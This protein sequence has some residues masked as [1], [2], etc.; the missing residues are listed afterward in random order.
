MLALTQALPADLG[1]MLLAVLKQGGE[2]GTNVNSSLKLLSSTSFC[3]L[4]SG[5]QGLL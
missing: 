2:L 5:W 4:Q 1:Q 3:P